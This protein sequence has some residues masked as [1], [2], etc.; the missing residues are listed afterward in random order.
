MD[1]IHCTVDATRLNAAIV[2]QSRQ[3]F[4]PGLIVPRVGTGD[5]NSQTSNP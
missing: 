4:L 2:E 5:S 3:D 1:A